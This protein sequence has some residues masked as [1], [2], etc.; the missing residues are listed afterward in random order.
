MYIWACKFITKINKNRIFNKQKHKNL[1]FLY[2]REIG[3]G[4]QYYSVVNMKVRHN[5]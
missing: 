2:S 1:V 3:I 5:Y 4:Y